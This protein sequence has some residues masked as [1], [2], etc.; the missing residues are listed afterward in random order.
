M[1]KRELANHNEK[2]NKQLKEKGIGM[3]TRGWLF[4][5]YYGV[6]SLMDGNNWYPKKNYNKIRL[7]CNLK[8][9]K[10]LIDQIEKSGCFEVTD[11][12]F[13]SLLW[14]SDAVGMLSASGRIPKDRGKRQSTGAAKQSAKTTIKGAS[15]TT[16]Q[17]S[18]TTDVSSATTFYD[19]IIIYIFIMIIINMR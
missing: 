4:C 10:I 11:S 16:K 12:G 5:L 15:G 13:R 17:S 14:S 3:A 8:S 9:N 19:I 7:Y 2:L 6:P 1:N 18:A